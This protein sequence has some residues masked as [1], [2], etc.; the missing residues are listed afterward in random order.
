MTRKTRTMRID[1]KLFD[2]IKRIAA[3]NQMKFVDASKL[4]AIKLSR[5]NG[6]RFK[7]VEEIE[8]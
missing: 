3:K 1:T 5:S 4:A 6:K 2:E 8:F 7:F